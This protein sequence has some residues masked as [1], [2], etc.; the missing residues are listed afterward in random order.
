M[1]LSCMD[2]IGSE[3]INSHRDGGGGDVKI[4]RYCRCFCFVSRKCIFSS[5]LLRHNRNS[6][7]LQFTGNRSHHHPRR[8]QCGY[9]QV[10]DVSLLPRVKYDHAR[11]MRLDD[12]NTPTTF[13]LT[14]LRKHTNIKQAIIHKTNG[15]WI[16]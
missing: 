7:R 16:T 1:A 3:Q 12:A 6:S 10:V 5:V 8:G 15:Q 9:E 14:N 4:C 11:G 13:M 2:W